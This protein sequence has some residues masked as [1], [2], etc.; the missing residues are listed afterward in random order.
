M[1][2]PSS[3]KSISTCLSFLLLPVA[4]IPQTPPPQEP[5]H[6]CPKPKA[7]PCASKSPTLPRG[8]SDKW[9]KLQRVDAEITDEETRSFQQIS[10]K[11][12]DLDLQ[13]ALLT[14]AT[15]QLCIKQSKML[16]VVATEW[17]ISLVEQFEHNPFLQNYDAQ[18]LLLTSLAR[19]GIQN[20]EMGTLLQTGVHQ[21]QEKWSHLSQLFPQIQPAGITAPVPASLPPVA[22]PVTAT[23]TPT[24]AVVVPPTPALPAAAPAP[25]A[26]PEAQ[27]FDKKLEEVDHLADS[28]DPQE[29]KKAIETL[30]ALQSESPKNQATY[31]MLTEKLATIC[32]QAVQ[33]LR[34]LAAKQ[35]QDAL[36][37]P[38]GT[39]RTEYLQAAEKSLQQAMT[40]K[41]A[42]PKTLQ[43]VEENLNIIQENMKKPT[44]P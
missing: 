25:A 42:K 4:C 40:Y 14:A 38:E 17:G 31:G 5:V 18:V 19:C 2:T 8:A 13:M 34:A 15:L 21:R 28:T 33:Q 30:R 36:P 6:V 12:S 11:G 35:F 26:T 43:R 44:R 16:D 39:M 27:T 29:R 32:E 22:T 20:P 37:L 24:P 7:L 23:I 3:V 1:R 9:I 10:K 41:E